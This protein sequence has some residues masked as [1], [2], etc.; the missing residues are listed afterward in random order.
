MN[1]T[2]RLAIRDSACLLNVPVVRGDMALQ[3]AR[4][5]YYTSRQ[6][7][8]RDQLLRQKASFE[9]VRLAQ[10]A[11][12]RGGNQTVAQLEEVVHRLQAMAEA[13]AQ[14]V[15]TLTQPELTEA[16]CLGP[17]SKTKVISSKDTAFSW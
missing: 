11:E 13:A 10:D 17:H 16:P 12:L 9:L 8:V 15:S 3:I 5:N 2:V 14:R 4:Q 7:E 1:N 6:S